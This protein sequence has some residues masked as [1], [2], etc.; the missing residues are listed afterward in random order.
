MSV[1]QMCL[2]LSIKIFKII[3]KITWKEVE[4]K[5]SKSNENC[6]YCCEKTYT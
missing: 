4:D 5:N 1:K 2:G 3:K 6:Y